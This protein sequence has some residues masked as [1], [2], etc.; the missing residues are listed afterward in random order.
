MDLVAGL[1][2]RSLV[3]AEDG[4]NGTRYR[5]LETIRQYGEQRLADG[6]EIGQLTCRH[7]GFYKGL[8]ASY[9]NYYGP[10]QLKWARQMKVERDNILAAVNNAVDAGDTKLAVQ[11]VASHPFQAKAEGPTGE[12]VAIEAPAVL[13]MPG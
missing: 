3:V 2:A 13:E 4:P 10:E 8:S 5:L 9:E 7:G 11:L 12:A 6:D 1:V